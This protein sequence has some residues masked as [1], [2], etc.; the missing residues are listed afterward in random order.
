MCILTKKAWTFEIHA[1]LFL[2]IL[3][4]LFF[5]LKNVF[6]SSTHFST[7]PLVNLAWFS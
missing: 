1:F 3:R 7:L 2:L 6:N 4:L 5:Y